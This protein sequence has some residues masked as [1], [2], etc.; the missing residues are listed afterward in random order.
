MKLQDLNNFIF[1]DVLTRA[2]IKEKLAL[3]RL[4]VREARLATPDSKNIRDLTRQ[5]LGNKDE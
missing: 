3:N 5:L 1:E 4:I 2:K